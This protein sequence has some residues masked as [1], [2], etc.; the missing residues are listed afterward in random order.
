MKMVLAC[1]VVISMAACG[2]D[3]AEPASNRVADAN[4]APRPKPKPIDLSLGAGYEMRH[5]LRE[6][7]LMVI[8]IVATAPPPELH[9]VTLADGVAGRTVTVKEIGRGD[10]FEVDHVRIRNK[11]A[12]P[13]FV[14]TGE[15][16][17]DG[18]QD[19]AIAED[20]LIRPGETAKVE[21][22]CVEQG[23]EKGHTVFRAEGV[24]AELGLR[25]Q[26][27]FA[28]QEDVWTKVEQINLAHHLTP[29]TRTYR[30]AAELQHD[31]DALA[32]RGELAHQ[33]AALPDRD[34]LVG[35]VLA[36]DNAVV[37]VDRFAT[38]ELYGALESEL[39]GS[40][41]ASDGLPPHEGKTLV[42]D[43][44]RAFLDPQRVQDTWSGKASRR[45]TDASLVVLASP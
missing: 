42:P 7:N 19:R 36:V 43:D 41:L 1:V 27:V 44:V 15:L 12:V 38:P 17:Y 33:L 22:R 16:I 23:R 4:P 13:L 9:V 30:D 11:G 18:L 6:G 8:P 3:G 29:P 14:M 24:L 45:V 26:M 5:P 39:L 31:R 34:R 37:E 2:E 21:V 32:K 35:L 40:Y 10:R 20:R 28:T 25:Q